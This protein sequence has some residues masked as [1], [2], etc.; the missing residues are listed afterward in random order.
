[1]EAHPLANLVHA[2][3]PDEY[4]ELVKSIKEQGQIHPIITLDGKI[5]DGRHRFKAVTELGL[6]PMTEEYR[7]DNPALFVVAS[8]VN[9]RHLTASQRAAVV[10]RVTDFMTKA[11]VGKSCGRGMKNSNDH[12]IVAMK[13]TNDEAA[14]AA[15]VGVATVVR[16]KRVAKESPELFAKIERGEVTA[17]EAVQQVRASCKPAKAAPKLVAPTGD[18]DIASHADELRKTIRSDKRMQSYIKSRVN[19]LAKID[20][21]V[22]RGVTAQE[23]EIGALEIIDILSAREV[24]VFRLFSELSIVHQTILDTINPKLKN[25]LKTV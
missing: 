15:G 5:L 1:M 3:K 16:A 21:D 6:D 12:V 2:M 9:R 14:K 10:V 22:T 11:D 25:A 13:T 18:W 17:N 19:R 23:L 7:G 24:D 4:T 8:N 20:I